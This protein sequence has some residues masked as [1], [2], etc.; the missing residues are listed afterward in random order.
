MEN[1]MTEDILIYTGFSASTFMNFADKIDIT[2]INQF[3]YFA[4]LLGTLIVTC[5]KLYRYWK[6]RNK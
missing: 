1:T 6:N 2:T 3:M 4:V 5:F